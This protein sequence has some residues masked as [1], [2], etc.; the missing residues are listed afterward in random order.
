MKATVGLQGSFKNTLAAVTGIDSRAT[1]AGT[2]YLTGPAPAAV[3]ELF[4][5]A[6]VNM[7]ARLLR[8][9]SKRQVQQ[10]KAWD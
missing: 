5:G 4:G 3:G 9:E 6:V 7:N 10:E 1:T 2:R 8:I